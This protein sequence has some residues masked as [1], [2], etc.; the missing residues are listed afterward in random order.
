[1][2]RSDFNAS[3]RLWTD[4]INRENK[5]HTKPCSVGDRSHIRPNS[6]AHKIPDIASPQVRSHLINEFMLSHEAASAVS[7]EFKFHSKSPAN[8]FLI[9]QVWWFLCVSD[10]LLVFITGVWLANWGTGLRLFE[11]WGF[12]CPE[13]YNYGFIQSSPCWGPSLVTRVPES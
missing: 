12:R 4:R 13:E 8:A 11:T 9:P 5:T 10:C 6:L 1:M 3:D 7:K 2:S